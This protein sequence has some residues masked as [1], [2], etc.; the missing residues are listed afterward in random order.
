MPDP[1][2]LTDIQDEV[3]QQ[4]E[5]EMLKQNQRLLTNANP[6]TMSRIP[7]TSWS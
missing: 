1:D 3:L 7:D 5:P 6:A 2:Q 4:D